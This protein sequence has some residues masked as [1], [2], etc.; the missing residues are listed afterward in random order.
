MRRYRARLLGWWQTVLLQLNLRP[1]ART[2][3]LTVPSAAASAV[4]PQARPY[5]DIFHKE[6]SDFTRLTVHTHDPTD[7]KMVTTYGSYQS[8]EEGIKTPHL[9]VSVGVFSTAY[10][11]AP[12]VEA[13]EGKN[14]VRH[15]AAIGPLI[16]RCFSITRPP[17]HLSRSFH[18]F[19]SSSLPPTPSATYHE[20][21]ERAPGSVGYSEIPS[22]LG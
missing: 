2:P 1:G 13:Y 16:C 17:P 19:L 3:Y 18:Y 14:S 11:A 12:T 8:G 6:E 21:N 20:V 7:K 15:S 4:L 10:T 5:F 22:A 9:R